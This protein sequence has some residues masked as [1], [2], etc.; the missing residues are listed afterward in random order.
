MKFQ[1]NVILGKRF[2]CGVL[3]CPLPEVVLS[4]DLIPSDDYSGRCI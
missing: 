2:P 1:L 3:A 4:V